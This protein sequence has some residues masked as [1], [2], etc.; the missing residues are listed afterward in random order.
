M[1]VQDLVM[2]LESSH[3]L[4]NINHHLILGVGIDDINRKDL[5]RN[6]IVDSVL[7][8]QVLQF[9]DQFLTALKVFHTGF[10]YQSIGL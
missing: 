10:Q 1:T 7:S 4:D 6:S 5:N 3:C 2:T 8:Y 9:I